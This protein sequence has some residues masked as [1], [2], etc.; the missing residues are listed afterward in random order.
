MIIQGSKYVLVIVYHFSRY[1]I[2][3]PLTNKTAEAVAHALIAYLF[4]PYSAP[5]VLFSD[6]GAE[7]RKAVLAEICKQFQIKQTFTVADHPASNG[8]V[9]RANIKVLKILPPTVSCLLDLWEDWLLQVS[10]SI[11][12]SPCE[13]TGQSP[14][15]IVFG[16]ENKFPYDLL[17]SPQNPVYNFDDYAKG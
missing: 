16:V 3:A 5:R 10:A 14:H 1:V 6:N 9:E 2:L 13:S 7:F 11:N 12:G 4:S 8:L 15:Y 17:S